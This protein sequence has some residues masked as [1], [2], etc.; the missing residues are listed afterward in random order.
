[1]TTTALVCTITII[2]LG[3]Y[4]H[5]MVQTGGVNKS[6]SRWLQWCGKY[7]F[8]VFVF[9]YIAGHV[10]GFTACPDSPELKPPAQAVQK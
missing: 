3:M 10:W 6:I 9:G 5:A 1:M 4:D 8:I 2:C 7:P